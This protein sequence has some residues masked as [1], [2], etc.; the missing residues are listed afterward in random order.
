[1]TSQRVRESRERKPAARLV[2]TDQRQ[3]E[4]KLVEPLGTAEI[5]QRGALERGAERRLDRRAQSRDHH[6]GIADLELARPQPGLDLPQQLQIE[7]GGGK[8]RRLQHAV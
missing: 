1:M 7:V 2:A 4:L 6:G 8:V 5:P 3:L